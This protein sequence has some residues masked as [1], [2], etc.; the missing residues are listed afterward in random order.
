VTVYEQ[1]GEVAA[2]NF[3]V[4]EIIDRGCAFTTGADESY[5]LTSEGNYLDIQCFRANHLSG[6]AVGNNIVA[7]RLDG[8][9]EH[10][11]GI[12]ASR[13]INHTLGYN[14]I[15]ASINNALGPDTQLGP[16][17]DRLATLLGDQSSDLILGFSSPRGYAPKIDPANFVHVIDNKYLPMKPGTTYVYRGVSDAGKL[18]NVMTI[19]RE[20]KVILGVT[21]VVVR[22]TVYVDGLREEQTLDWYAQDKFGNVW[23]F[24]ENSKEYDPQ[25]Q[26]VIS[27]EGSWMAGVKGA[28]PGIVME[29]HPR[30]GDKY[31]QE[32]LKGV[33]EDMAQILSLDRDVTTP[34]HTYKDCLKTQEWTPLEPGVLEYKYC[35][36]GIGLVYSNMVKGGLERMWLWKTFTW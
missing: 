1:T 18:L 12:W 30:V 15:E 36:S 34:V 16:Y 3:S 5:S 17:Q 11:E 9:L 6:D 33:A 19:T 25:T 10:P 29:A 24:G 23:Y 31:R 13:I 35:K 26:K 20:T 7:V 28:M 2:Y 21:C 8:V 27:T 4:R 32:Y 14:G 22:D